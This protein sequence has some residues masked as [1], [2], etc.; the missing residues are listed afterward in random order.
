MA[1]KKPGM[2]A[3][4]KGVSGPISSPGTGTVAG[5]VDNAEIAYFDQ[6]GDDW[7]DPKGPFAALQ[8]MTPARVAYIRQQVVRCLGRSP[9]DRLDGLSVLD[10]GCGGGL[11]AEPLARLGAEVT[12]VDASHEAI[13]AARR[14]AEA[15]GLTID[16]RAHSAE[17]LL[18]EGQYFDLIIASEVIEHTADRPAFLSLM[19]GFADPDPARPALAVLT[20]LNRS[21]PGVVL[22]KYAAEYVLG[23]APKGAHDPK[24]FVRPSELQRE[25]MAAGIQLDDITGIRPSLL[26]GFDLGGPPLINYAA[27]GLVQPGP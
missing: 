16:Y 19:A 12:G 18:A 24:R 20:T 11:L 25:A 9:Q 23:L 5:T 7:W 2:K 26:K 6:L 8:R 4:D 22:G 17:D 15:S 10:I 14:H 27:A 3:D 21:L 1:G 13:E